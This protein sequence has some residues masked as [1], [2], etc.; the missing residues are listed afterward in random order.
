MRKLIFLVLAFLL[1]SCLLFSGIAFGAGS[2]F[3]VTSDT[4]YTADAGDDITE[5]TRAIVMTFTADDTNGSIPSLTFSTDGK[6][7]DGTLLGVEQPL[8]GWYCDYI[9]IDANH[10]GTEPDEDSDITITH[11]GLD[12]L[13]G[14]GT[15]MVDNTDEND[16]VFFV[17]GYAVTAPIF[18]SVVVAISN[19]TVNDATGTVT[20]VM[21][22]K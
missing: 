2:S 15:D 3:V 7:T 6:W 11:A 4:V 16:V 5:T 10:A 22:L 12:M 9:H 21:G 8:T 20:L 17:A 18:G 19:N 14:G 1:F 13:N